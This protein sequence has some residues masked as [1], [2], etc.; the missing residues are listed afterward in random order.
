MYLDGSWFELWYSLGH[1]DEEDEGRVAVWQFKSVCCTLQHG[2]GHSD[3]GL[4]ARPLAGD[5]F[6]NVVVTKRHLSVDRLD[7]RDDSVCYRHGVFWVVRILDQG[8]DHVF[9]R[10]S[11]L[12]LI[13]E[14]D[15]GLDEPRHSPE[16][17]VVVRT[18]SQSTD[19]LVVWWGLVAT[20]C[21]NDFFHVFGQF[22]HL[23]LLEKV[24]GL[25]TC[26]AVQSPHVSDDQ[27]GMPLGDGQDQFLVARIDVV[28]G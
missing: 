28:P 11:E 10:E 22:R 13:V 25:S 2:D 17:A 23:D 27:S 6:L 1:S 14:Y 4:S 12:S 19:E 20:N 5:Q 3:L 26:D 24:F 15:V 21:P 8:P 16:G 9:N 7:D 18:T